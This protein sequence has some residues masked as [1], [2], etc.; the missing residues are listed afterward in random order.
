MMEFVAGIV[1]GL[2]VWPAA[3]WAYNKL[4]RWSADV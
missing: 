2:I 3:K 4:T 1:T